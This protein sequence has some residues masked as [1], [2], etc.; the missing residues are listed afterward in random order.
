MCEL[1]WKIVRPLANNAPIEKLEK[2][3]GYS[4]PDDYIECV[5]KHNAG[6]PSLKKFETLTG[7]EHICNNLL[8]FNEEKAVNVF[9][10]YDSMLNATGNRA[11]LP[12][13]ED[14]FGNYICFELSET[15]AKVVFWEHETSNIEPICDTFTEFVSK[16]R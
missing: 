3:I 8:S 6:Y 11:L 4:L 5:Q 1:I 2:I 7:V 10:T 12:F 16:L 14:P 15:H 13:A 9:N